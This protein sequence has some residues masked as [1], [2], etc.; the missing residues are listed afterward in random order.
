MQLELDMAR[1]AGG[2][3]RKPTEA[4]VR[5]GLASG[6]QDLLL[7]EASGGQGLLLAEAAGRR[8]KISG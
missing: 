4:I 5:P 6:G 2:Q 7:T 3:E 8:A 1:T